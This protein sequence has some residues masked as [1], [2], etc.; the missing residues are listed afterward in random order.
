MTV[1]WLIMGLLGFG[2]LASTAWMYVL[3]VWWQS[4][5]AEQRLRNLKEQYSPLNSPAPEGGLLRSSLEAKTSAGLWPVLLSS[6]ARRQLI[7][8]GF[9]DADDARHFLLL[10]LA[11]ALL[12]AALTGFVLLQR[13][14]PGFAPDAAVTV[15]K[16]TGAGIAAFFVPYFLLLRIA[17]S[18]QQAVQIHF[19]NA[20]DLIRVC[21]EAGMSLDAAL[22]RVGQE[23]ENNSALL[24]HAF[25]AVSLKIQAGASHTQALADLPRFLNLDEMAP[26]VSSLLQSEKLGTSMA[27]TLKTYSHELRIRK[28][29]RAEEMSGKLQ[30]KLLFPL[31]FC[32]LPALLIILMGPAILSLRS[33]FQT[34][35]GG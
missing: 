27:T 22:N 21:V 17:N 15:L 29:L 24:H 31:I 16:M 19:A 8:A 30:T 35:A 20:L 12:G 14:D 3:L 7:F 34:G 13:Q 28:R 5:A 32:L 4:K 6:R 1:D 18:A 11:C 33:L 26:L 2:F 10:R 9:Y 23:F 25:Q